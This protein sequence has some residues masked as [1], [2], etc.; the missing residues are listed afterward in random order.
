MLM[1]GEI[2]DAA[3]ASLAVQAALSGHRLIT[4]FHAATPGGAI[5]R[6]LEMGIEPYQL[7]SSIYGVVSQRLVRRKNPQGDPLGRVPIAEFVSM[8][9]ALRNAVLTHSDA[10]SL[11]EVYRSQPG[12][13][14]LADA[15]RA[16]VEAGIADP[17]DV[18]PIIASSG[19]TEP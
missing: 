16:M 4:T 2:R 17:A 19:P 6:L 1:L 18:Q 3:T 15:A 14:S 5:A 10:D 13:Q 7:T 8:D 12:Y 11:H 9:S